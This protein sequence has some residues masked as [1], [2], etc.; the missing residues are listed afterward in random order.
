M[1]MPNP[2]EVPIDWA[3]ISGGEAHKHCPACEY[4]GGHEFNQGA[5][6]S[7]PS[8]SS[9]PQSRPS[10]SPGR[11]V[12]AR[13]CTLHTAESFSLLRRS[14]LVR[15]LRF[16]FDVYFSLPQ[17][18]V[19]VAVPGLGPRLCIVEPIFENHV[20]MNPRAGAIFEGSDSDLLLIFC[21]Q[22]LTV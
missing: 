4:D 18:S 15:R 2:E 19:F 14:R 7:A 13:P 8:P 21:F 22:P 11:G 12:I 9:R 10:F 20:E 5:G 1:E 17:Q 3:P 16:F 6:P